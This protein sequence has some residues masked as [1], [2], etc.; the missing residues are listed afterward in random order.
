MVINLKLLIK[1]VTSVIHVTDDAR[2]QT[3]N[4]IN[5]IDESIINKF[6]FKTLSEYKTY[7]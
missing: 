3:W 4:I 5:K 6:T 1:I 7:V 2:V